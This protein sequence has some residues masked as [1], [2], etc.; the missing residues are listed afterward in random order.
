MD[1]QDYEN[2]KREIEELRKELRGTTSSLA[3]QVAIL[4]R[5]K[6]DK[7]Q[8]F[9]PIVMQPYQPTWVSDNTI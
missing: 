8:S 4:Q 2:L 6:A 5:N 7:T 1:K 3:T 9:G